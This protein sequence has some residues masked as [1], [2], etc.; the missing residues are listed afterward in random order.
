MHFPDLSNV[1]GLVFFG[2]CGGLA[3]PATLPLANDPSPMMQMP[4]LETFG[5]QGAVVGVLL[6]LV[7]QSNN[8]RVA[9]AK[10]FSNRSK[11]LA[12]TYQQ[13]LLQVTAN[14]QTTMADLLKR[15]LDHYEQ[16]PEAKT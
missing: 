11:D 8:S 5:A 14:Y 2:A 10:D 9:E 4:G 15:V 7:V 12:N 1:L 16:K 13:Q 6:W 3:L